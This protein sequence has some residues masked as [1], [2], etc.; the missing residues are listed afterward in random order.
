MPHTK[1]AS[2]P[3][4]QPTFPGS[5]SVACGEPT[6]ASSARI[7]R[8]LFPRAELFS[9]AGFDEFSEPEIDLLQLLTAVPGL[10]VR[11]LFDFESGNPALFGHLEANYRRFRD[12]GFVPV[13]DNAPARRIFPIN[14]ISRSP[15]TGKGLDHIAR[16]LFLSTHPAVRMDLRSSVT[17][18]GAAGRREEVSGICRLM[19]HLLVSEPGLDPAS[20]CVAML[21]PQL[22]TDLFREECRRFG[23]PANITDRFDLS[24]SPVVTNIL[25]LLRVPVGGFLRTDVLRVVGAPH[26]TFRNS[27]PLDA[28][29]LAA[30]SGALRITGGIAAWK[31][32][33]EERRVQIEGSKGEEKE[34]RSILAARRDIEAVAEAVREVATPA[35]PALFVARVERLL[36]R[37]EFRRNLVAVPDPAIAERDARAFAGFLDAL[38][39]MAALLEFQNG[40]RE[41]HPLRFYLEQLTTAVIRER[42][43]V[44]EEFGAGV[45]ITSIDETRGLPMRVMIL[46]GCVDGEFPEPYQT[47]VFLSAERRRERERRAVWQNRYLFYQAVTN[48]T[49]HCYLTFP[50]SAGGKDLVPSSFIDSLRSVILTEEWDSISAAPWAEGIFSG[51]ELYAWAVAHPE[52]PIPRTD[53]T[54]APRLGT[55]QHAVAVERSRATGGSHPGHRGIIAAG[56]S[57]AATRRLQL[58]REEPF[59]ITALES[60]GKCP[61]QYF[62]GRLLGLSPPADLEEELTSLERGSLLHEALFEFFTGRRDAEKPPLAGCSDEEFRSAC[63]DLIGLVE[64]KLSGFDIPDP[65]WQ[66]DRELLLKGGGSAHGRA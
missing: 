9:L 61:F 21:R 14:T 24:R 2:P 35:P 32:R 16:T 12:L 66:I 27:P 1:N 42:Y 40:P 64:K 5:S 10:T 57:P 36:A 46:A 38:Q 31:G 37:L 43:N 54:Y 55:V 39:E 30:I 23:I 60:Y 25:G 50:R 20:I 47:E 15:E 19:K 22:Y 6:R 56:L 26:F 29:N 7:F 28:P 44:R 11:L 33:L 53:D 17:V 45:L 3:S 63:A 41:E 4:R 52:T 58:H 34:L 48:W 62:A 59:S 8:S 49:D 65:F 13:R 51:E 18:A